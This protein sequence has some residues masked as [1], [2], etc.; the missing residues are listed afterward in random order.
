MGSHRWIHTQ[1]FKSQIAC[2]SMR[3][4]TRSFWPSRFG[5]RL[6]PNKKHLWAGAHNGTAQC[7]RWR[8]PPRQAAGLRSRKSVAPTCQPHQPTRALKFQSAGTRLQLQGQSPILSRRD[9]CADTAHNSDQHAWA[10]APIPSINRIHEPCPPISNVPFLSA[11][12]PR[13][14]PQGGGFYHTPDG[15]KKHRNSRQCDSPDR[16]HGRR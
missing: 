8:W 2:N 1:P 7:K 6:N 5:Q 3:I 10:D 9:L 14:H 11:F 13:Q 12:Q 15:P 4:R 16:T